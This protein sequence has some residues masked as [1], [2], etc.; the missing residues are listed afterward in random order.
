MVC[1]TALGLAGGALRSTCTKSTA[2][3]R[4]LS[5]ESGLLGDPP[6][7]DWS[8][9]VYEGDPA[10]NLAP[11]NNS[12]YCPR[13]GERTINGCEHCS[14]AIPGDVLNCPED[15]FVFLGGPSSYERP[16]YCRGCG[17]PFPWTVSALDAAKEYAAE[18]EGL[19]DD[20]RRLLSESLDDLVTEGPRTAI[21]VSRFRRIAGKAGA[22]AVEGFRSILVDVMSEAVR[23]QMFGG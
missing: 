14:M 13:C 18:I 23:K 19:S 21:A 12:E 7:T 17:R 1:V 4:L 11:R 9:P 15:E 6:G 16:A 5:H 22:G 2:I 10:A 20:E 8:V 3:R